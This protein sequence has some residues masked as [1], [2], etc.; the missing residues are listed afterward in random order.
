M[1]VSL[2]TP[3]CLGDIF[4]LLLGELVANHIKKKKSPVHKKFLLA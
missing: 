4:T 3:G 1:D 2:F